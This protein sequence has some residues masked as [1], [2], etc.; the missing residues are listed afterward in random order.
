MAVLPHVL[1]APGAGAAEDRF[2][3]RNPRRVAP[4]VLPRTPLPGRPSARP[5]R[6]PEPR[7]RQ[8]RARARSRSMSDSL[9]RRA[10]EIAWSMIALN[11]RRPDAP[12][13]ASPFRLPCPLPCPLRSPSTR[14][15]RIQRRH[16]PVDEA[17]DHVL[18]GVLGGR[19]PAT[20]A[21]ARGEPR[22]REQRHHPVGVA[23]HAAGIVV[24]ERVHAVLHVRDLG[25]VLARHRGDERR[26]EVER[27]DH[28]EAH[29]PGHENG[30]GRRQQRVALA[31]VERAVVDEPRRGARRRLDARA[32]PAR[33]RRRAARSPAARPPRAPPP[34]A[35]S[36][37]ACART[38]RR[39]RRSA[40]RACP[41]RCRR[42]PARPACCSRP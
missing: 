32:H 28:H 21:Q 2:G 9:R 19:L 26:L 12:R 24:H 10:A 14:F 38:A 5:R 18:D 29:E 37:G 42:C 33:R 22:V 34:R 16:D 4:A 31:A 13:P 35:G 39:C 7:R 17:R 3:Q 27:V 30:L 23:S 1:H 41:V 40:R 20:R 15:L 11:G 6:S 36:R 25:A 8:P